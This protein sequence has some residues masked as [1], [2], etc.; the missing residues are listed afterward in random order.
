MKK[1]SARTKYILLAIAFFILILA[2]ILVLT[3]S[4]ILGFASFFIPSQKPSLDSTHKITIVRQITP[5][6]DGTTLVTLKIK[7]TPS[8][9]SIILT[10]SAP[11]NIQENS[12][13]SQ[14]QEKNKIF[15]KQPTPN[16][17]QIILLRD[18]TENTLTYKVQGGATKGYAGTYESTDGTKGKF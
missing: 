1:R 2:V 18:I 5:Q 17:F 6:T 14:V 3:R 10:E 7:Q 11:A 12:F 9:Y 13:T 15:T 4:N 16:S 8:K